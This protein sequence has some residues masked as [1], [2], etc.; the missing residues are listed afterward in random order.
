MVSIVPGLLSGL[1]RNRGPF[2]AG[3][4]IFYLHIKV[5][6]CSG[7]HPASYSMC[8]G[9]LSLEVKFLERES[10]TTPSRAEVKNEFRLNHHSFICLHG[11]HRDTLTFTRPVP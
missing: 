11:V 8:T 4:S 3:A 7:A 6:T 10:D 5:Q 1:E 9:V 2:P